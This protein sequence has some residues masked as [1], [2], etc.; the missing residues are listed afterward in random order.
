MTG[1]V[2]EGGAFRGLFTAGVLDA[3]LDMDVHFPVVCGVSAGATNACSYLS[4][5]RGRN[6]EIMERYL[7]DPR[8][9]GFR[10]LVTERAVM[11]MN[12][13]FDEI[14]KT[15]IP[16]DY[17]SFHAY[18]GRFYT[19]VCHVK[20]GETR[21]F[22]QSVL[23]EHNTLLRASCSIPLLF[24]LVKIQGELYADGGLSDPVPIKQAQA[25]GCEKSIVVFTRP[26]GYIKRSSRRDRLT[27]RYLNLRYPALAKVVASRARVYNEQVRNCQRLEREGRALLFYAPGEIAVSRFERSK[28]T[29]REIYECGYRTA[30]E[31]KERILAFL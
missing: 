28:Q 13:V 9:F 15:E 7:N 30:T 17:Q 22:D 4:G 2:L 26:K 14:P 31:K 19:G 29:L 5:Q 18:A 10:N 6:L 27:A 20:S 24:P 23:D 8:Y 12:F 16:F 21:F 1:L 3:L 25:V 11:N